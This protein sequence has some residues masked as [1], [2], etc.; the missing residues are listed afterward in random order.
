MEEGFKPNDQSYLLLQVNDLVPLL[1]GYEQNTIEVLLQK[2][3]SWLALDS[4]N[5]RSP[6][7]RRLTSQFMTQHF[8]QRYPP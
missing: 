8:A 6:G 4:H 7:E 5:W 3:N 1:S 2:A